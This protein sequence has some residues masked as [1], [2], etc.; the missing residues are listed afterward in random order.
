MKRKI[1]MSVMVIGIAAAMLGA[2]TFSYFSDTEIA[3]NNTF[4]AGTIDI[5]LNPAAYGGQQVETIEGDLDLK[6]CQTG[7]TY[8]CLTNDGNNPCEVW[9]H[10]NNV[11]N[12]ENGIV[13]PEQEYYNAW[14]A[15][16]P[17]WETDGLIPPWEWCIS[18]W[19]HYDM[20]VCKPTAPE[21]FEL[22]GD[23]DNPTPP[24][25]ALD[26]PRCPTDPDATVTKY[27]ECGKVKWDIELAEI[28]AGE[29][30]GETYDHTEFG[31]VIAS[32]AGIPVFH[33][34]TGQM[35]GPD[36]PPVI[37]EWTG[38]EWSDTMD[39]YDGIIVTNPGGTGQPGY[40]DRV[41]H[42]EI[43]IKYLGGCGATYYWSVVVFANWYSDTSGWHYYGYSQYPAD[44]NRWK[45]EGRYAENHVGT[46][47]K[48]IPET[49]GWFLTEYNTH[50]GL[51]VQCKWI[52]LGILQPGECMVVVQSYHLDKDVDNW[53]Q[54]DKV[55]FDMEFLLE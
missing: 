26:D 53:G 44:W 28:P 15:A 9:K 4:T 39:L 38:S 50:T 37:K 35:H 7:Y 25:F 24:D 14:K 32:S 43:P 29:P 5:S 30:D 8:T 21:I 47:I 31:L 36:S 40:G 48:E 27:I 3:K 33:I 45:G 42:I 34:S 52:Y 6:P 51:G 18:D 22:I 1:L 12:E 20:I 23:R 49:E 17:D 41:F 54:S 13:E 46:V 10:I 11:E 16:N 19:I 2:G 55:T